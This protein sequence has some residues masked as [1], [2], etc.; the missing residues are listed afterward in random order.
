MTEK[1]SK[2]PTERLIP[3]Q[4]HLVKKV[5]KAFHRL[6]F[7][8]PVVSQNLDDSPGSRSIRWTPESAHYVVDVRNALARAIEDQPDRKALIAAWVRILADDSTIRTQES[9]IIGLLA[10]VLSDRELDPMTALRHIKRG[11][12]LRRAA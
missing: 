8:E 5:A 6:R 12:P 10:P 9:R 3:W 1:Q 2:P 11:R 7:L 4:L